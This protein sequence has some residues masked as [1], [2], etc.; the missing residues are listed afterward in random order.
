MEKALNIQLFER[1]R[2]GI[3]TTPQGRELLLS[4]RRVLEEAQGFTTQAALLSGR[5]YGNL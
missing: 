1:T 3:N 2:K 4:A 5:R